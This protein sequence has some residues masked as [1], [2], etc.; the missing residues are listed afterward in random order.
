MHIW[1]EEGKFVYLPQ[2]ENKILELLRLELIYSFLHLHS[3]ETEAW[4]ITFMM[5]HWMLNASKCCLIF[6]TT[7]WSRHFYIPTLMIRKHGL[8]VANKPAPCN[9]AGNWQTWESYPESLAAQPIHTLCALCWCMW[10]PIRSQVS[11]LVPFSIRPFRQLTFPPVTWVI[12]HF[13]EVPFWKK[14]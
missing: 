10:L 11:C 14:I 3:W 1:G 5:H 6:M 4:G 7:L 12:M 8:R 2:W 13:P 9:M